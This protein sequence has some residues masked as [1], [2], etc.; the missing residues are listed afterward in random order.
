MERSVCRCDSG[1]TRRHEAQNVPR[2]RIHDYKYDIIQ[3]QNIHAYLGRRGFR[4]IFWSQTLSS[5]WRAWVGIA[6]VP[7]EKTSPAWIIETRL[8]SNN[9]NKPTCDHQ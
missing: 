9:K 7:Y 1:R 3:H 2:V 5:V 6:A 8:G 4:V